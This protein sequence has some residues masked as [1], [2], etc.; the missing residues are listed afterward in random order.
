MRQADR[1]PVG[2]DTSSL[3]RVSVSQSLGKGDC[4]AET[5]RTTLNSL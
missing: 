2:R 3:G 4:G 1:W 5:F